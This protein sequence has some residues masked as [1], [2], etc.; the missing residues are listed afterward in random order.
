MFQSRTHNCGELR[1]AHAGQ[2]VT[3]VGWLENVRE[4]GSNFAFCV[5]RDF[6]GTTQFV[7]EN[8]EMMDV[9]KPLNKES[10]VS[11]TGTVRVRESVNKKI[12]TGMI[13]VVPSEIKVLGRCRY[14]ELPFEINRSR[15]ADETLRLKYRYLDLRNPA[16]KNNIVLRCNVV[17][18]LRQAMG[19]E[20]FLEIT[21][22]ILTASSP[23]GARDYLVP[24]RK[25]P[26]KFYA[27]PQAP[28]QFKQLLMT[29]GFDR[30]FQI[31]PCFRDEDARGDRSPGEFYQLD[32]EM[33]FA[34]Q[35]DVFAVLER[36]LP[37]IF[38]KYGTYHVASEAPFKRISFLDAMEQYG[39][40]KPD[41]RI[42]LKVQDAT[43]IC[44]ATEFGPFQGQSVKAVVVPQCKLARKAIDKLCAEVE[45]QTGNKV[46]WCKMDD[47]GVLTGG[48]SKFLTDSTAAL[49][50]K[51]GL[52]AGD[53]V[54]FTAGKLLAAQKTAGVLR[55][56]LGNACPGHMDKERYEFCWIV[57]F[58]MYEI[59]EESGQLEFC[60]NPFSMPNGGLEI[61]EKAERGE[62]DPL[63]ITA[64]Q[65]DLVCNGVELSSGAVRNHDP[66]LMIKAFEMVRL[67]EEDVKAKFP[68][69][70][71][72]FCYGAPP[73]AGIAPGV[74]RMV[75][76]LAGEESIREII[77]FPMNKNAQDIMMDAPSA[78][79]E[80][81]LREVH[82]K[83]DLDQE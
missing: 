55:T 23:E 74:D 71:N 83:L 69:M 31:A 61:L 22:P 46:Y 80:K 9:V 8:K 81:Q 26:G 29:S 78:V 62:V 11:V 2:T 49:T 7:I 82:I 4:V 14:N 34:S 75:M 3:L 72:A 28:Q 5:L 65:Y 35:E 18:A 36:V 47:K 6:Y 77:P 57:D 24:A 30:Y 15:E 20:G 56:K 41:L 43:E 73:H 67:G 1:E 68:A 45:V 33:A 32:M 64:F 39:S 48:V 53:F 44:S 12:P 25:H 17:S 59:G 52:K 13:E 76:L 19:Q 10:T 70:Y 54:G 51:L 27:L 66:E 50:E 42:D 40:D 79:D 21:T 16:V 60:H 38:A 37:P 63:S 58:P